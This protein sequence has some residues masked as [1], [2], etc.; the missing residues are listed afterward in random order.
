M[1]QGKA[2]RNDFDGCM[3][4][5]MSEID[6]RW[7][8]ARENGRKIEYGGCYVVFVVIQSHR[9]HSRVVVVVVRV[10][11]GPSVELL[12]DLGGTR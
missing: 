5:P 10:R 8:Y 7:L 11:K 4:S 1:Q 6:E 9:G 2:P 3:P 12:T